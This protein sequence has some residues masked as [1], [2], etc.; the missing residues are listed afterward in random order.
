[1]LTTCAARPEDVG[2]NV[3]GID[4]YRDGVFDLGRHLDEDERCVPSMSGVE[5]ADAN[6]AMDAVLTFEEAVGA[7]PRDA[8]DPDRLA[9]RP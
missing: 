9:H 4:L 8:G 6:K 7:R 2:A 5:G 3:I 1:M